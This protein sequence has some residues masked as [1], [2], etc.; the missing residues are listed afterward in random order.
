[1]DTVKEKPLM[2]TVLGPLASLEDG[3]LIST[4][5]SLDTLNQRGYL[6]VIFQVLEG[7]P[8]MC[9]L[10]TDEAPEILIPTP[11][12]FSFILTNHSK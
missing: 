8:L 1:M 11:Y 9:S 12:F 10:E 6:I 2:K 4:Q 5:S 3:S 7:N